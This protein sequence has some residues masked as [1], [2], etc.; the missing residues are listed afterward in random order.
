[1]SRFHIF[2]GA[3]TA[4]DIQQARSSTAKNSSY[5]WIHSSPIPLGSDGAPIE[6]PEPLKLLSAAEVAVAYEHMSRILDV[7]LLEGP[8]KKISSGD[9]ESLHQLEM[10]EYWGQHPFS[11]RDHSSFVSLKVNA[12]NRR[13]HPR[14]VGGRYKTCLALGS[15]LRRF[16][17]L[18][19]EMQ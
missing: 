9:Q 2:S 3:P 10:S 17:S 1:M 12:W 7:S 5:T 6:P 4:R 16:Y 13:W 18:P 8:K 19:P 14:E 11:L 15:L